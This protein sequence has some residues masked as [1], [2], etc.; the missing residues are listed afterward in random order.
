MKNPLPGTNTGLGF[1]GANPEVFGPPSWPTGS[2]FFFSGT[3]RASEVAPA[4][5]ADGIAVPG[6]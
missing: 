3:S 5:L 1:P 2:A 4:A 6:P